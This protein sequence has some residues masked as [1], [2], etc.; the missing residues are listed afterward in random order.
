MMIGAS[1][2]WYRSNKP[3][4]TGGGG[5]RMP[6]FPG[7]AN[8]EWYFPNNCSLSLPFVRCIPEK[9]SKAVILSIL[10]C[11]FFIIFIIMLAFI[12]TSLPL[13]LINNIIGHLYEPRDP[14]HQ[15]QWLER[16]KRKITYDPNRAPPGDHWR[17][18]AEHTH[19]NRRTLTE[20]LAAQ[21]TIDTSANNNYW[22]QIIRYFPARTSGN[23]F[24][25][26]ALAP[27]PGDARG[28]GLRPPGPDLIR[29]S[30][31]AFDTWHCSHSGKRRLLSLMLWWP[32]GY[33][34]LTTTR[35]LLLQNR[36]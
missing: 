21:R 9:N 23:K 18:T 4:H 25:W 11:L 19:G 1:C 2:T 12:S 13:I 16:S 26:P 3:Q 15:R 14:H 17:T 7:A 27:R 10:I 31:F 24:S 33:R 28:L 34:R 20:I 8:S 30:T 6:A 29:R 36:D 5:Y 32:A 22:M 35:L